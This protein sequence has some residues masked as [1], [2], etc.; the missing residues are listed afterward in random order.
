MNS[1]AQLLRF[2]GWFAAANT[3]FFAL[4]GLRYLYI[5]QFPPDWIGALYVGLAFTG[6]FAVLACVPLFVILTPIVLLY[7]RRQ[8]VMLAGVLVASIGLS[9]LLLDT[10]VFAQY[11]FHLTRLTMELFEVTTWVF[12]AVMF[13]ILLF[14]QSMAAGI[15]WRNFV[16]RP[17][18]VRGGWVASLLVCCWL[19]GTGLYIWGDAV[20]YTSVTQFT[21]FMPLYFPI[22][23]KRDLAR[24]GL[25]D[26]KEVRKRRAIEGS[27]DINR[28]QLN[29]P[30][31]VMQCDE[32]QEQ[33]MNVVVV[34]IDAL[35]PD[36]ID[37][38]VTPNID[39]FRDDSIEFREHFSGGNSSRMGIFSFFYGIPSPYWQ[40]FYDL[41]RPPVL[42]NQ[43][44]ESG[45]EF[46]LFSA[47][48]F[49]S[50]SSIDRTVFAGVAELADE[51]H[52][53]S[54][55]QKN[56]A[57][58]DDWLNWIAHHDPQRPFFS[59]LYYD[60]P[61]TDMPESGEP[62]PMDDRFT[63]NPDARRRWHQ[64]QLAVQL[65]DAEVG[66]VLASL[67]ERKLLDNTV[68]MVTSDHGYELDDNG[69]GY[70]G[71]AS[72]FSRAQLRSTLLM[73]WP[74]REPAVFNNRTAHQDVPVTLLEDLFG[75]TNPVEDYAMGQS[76]FSGESWDWIIAGSY[77][78]YAIVQPDQVIVSY[79]G[80]FV[81][82]LGS[83]YRT[84]DDPQ[85]DAALIQ[86]SVL[87]MRRFFR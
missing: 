76:L 44:R 62:L 16:L 29:Y 61:M 26:P 22:H 25:V 3:V 19:S 59:F 15:I 9:L 83:D 70:I 77:S 66:R 2:T 37:A 18:L 72:N 78:N 46:A 69:L 63:S 21:R 64:Y 56:L 35:R 82:V 6:Q 81:E 49:G 79:P 39:A 10:N 20:A 40:T 14:F 24:L 33:P 75:C 58:T 53:V 8:V 87:E 55:T 51:N 4:V 48:G 84:V 38:A 27:L 54:S 50:P 32:N 43:F 86:E 12:T 23:A 28:G 34:L 67:R 31:S 85:F 5:Y 36:A 41:Q 65:I 30:A 71:H 45:Y 17:A 68:V 11:R 57:V 1:R 42:M 47:V 13:V 60:P 52:D 73:R 7:P 74:G 80:G